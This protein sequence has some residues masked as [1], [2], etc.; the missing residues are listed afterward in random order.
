MEKR[1]GVKPSPT[2]WVLP[3][4]CWQTS[5]KPQRSLYLLYT[6]FCLST[7]WTSTDANESRCHQ[8]K[9]LYGVGL[10]TGG[11]NHLQL[12]K[13][14]L[15]FQACWAA[16]CLDSA[17]HALWWLEGMCFQA[18]C[19][20]SQSCQPFRT[21][22]SNSMVIFF[23]KSQTA[24]DLGVLPEDGEPHLLRLSWGR[25]SWKRQ[26]LPG[27]PLT[28]SVPSSDHQSLLRDRQKRDHLSEVAT[29][30]VIQHSK[31]NHS[32]EAGAANRNASA[33]DRKAVTVPRPFTAGHTTHTPDWPKNVST[34]PESSEHASPASNT[35]HVKST[36]HSPTDTPL[37]VAPSYS[38]ATPTPPASFQS[39]SASH[40]AVKD[41]VVSAGRSVQITLPT[42]EVQLNAF[43]LP[44]AE[45]GE[46][47]TYDWQL[48]THP[49]DYSGEMER[50]HSQILQLSKLTP[51]LY[52]F[53]VIVDGQNAHGEGYVNVTVKPE[54][55][56][57]RP[58]IAI[59]S[60]QFQEISLPTTSTIIDGSQSTDDDK[61]VQYHWEELKGPLR[62][63]KI[64]EDTPILKLSKLVP[65]NYTFSLTVVDS[66]GATNSTTASL[67]VNK[68]VDYPPV[69]NAG[70]N[71]VITLP[72]NSITLFGNQSTD[73]HGITSYEWSLSPSSK[74]KVV[75]MQGVR[76]PTL[77]LSAMQEGDYTYQLTVTDTTG[78]QATAQVTVIVQPENN[79]PPQADA[80][81]DKELTLPVDSTTLDGSKSTDDQRIVSYLW[82]QTQ[83]PDGVQ[84][85]DANSSVATVTG[86][87]VGTYV[88]TLTVK[89]ERDLQ[90]QSSVNVIVKEEINKPP[91]AK[92]AGNVVVTLPTSTAE[93]D[94]SR[95]SDDKGIVSYLW[96][97]DEGSPAAGEVLNHSDHHPVLFLSNLV[98]GTYTFH[99]KVTDAKGESDTDR[100][101]VEVKPDPRKSNL[102]E[103]ILD[104]N[105]S[106]LTERLKGMFIRQIGVLLGVLDSDIIVQKIQPYTEQ[107]T[108]MLFFVQNEP[109]HQLFKGH[110]V[111]AML[112]SELRKQK[113]DF[114]IFRALEINTVTCQLN[115]SDHGHCDSFTKR[116][117]CDPFW[118]ENFIKVQLRDGDSNC[119]WSV[120]YVII[121]TFVI[122][123]AL[124]ILSWTTIC[125]CKRQKGK[126]KRKSRY[127]I[128]D[129]TDQESLE[130][131]PTSR[132]GSKQKGPMLSSSL[133]HS[134]SELDSDDAIFT[135]P[136][137]EKGKLLH[138]QNGSVPNGQTPLK[139]RSP[140]E[141]IL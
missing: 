117:V 1:L 55:R 51:G 92:I 6:F 108:K 64:S 16:C 2:S 109:P 24:N 8:G 141:E 11:E 44:E 61:I 139:T 15:P 49:K 88:F 70:P 34:H 114:L 57:N 53:K 52:E 7:L 104:V 42:N 120:L 87:Q 84:L 119:E 20:K 102:V 35:Q 78:Q 36:E 5:V 45:P 12:L 27:A 56:K 96:T 73:D 100:T 33:E 93:L 86:L 122:V 124:G 90:S 131:K 43:V 76:T 14:S 125:C 121:A 107:S 89:D 111:A 47:Y 99:L 106:Q 116:C 4:Y 98:E 126:P 97:R 75:E 26:S 71:Q 62:E 133:M 136:D 112:K 9:T 40:P 83:G 19:S 137:R 63:E 138:G 113:A 81:P 105:V 74:G 140:R 66:D 10:R 128:L 50:K 60:P 85:E 29:P 23:Q 77:Q 94:G 65:G 110:E 48:I 21:D 67:T 132:A 13:G 58:P 127:K 95:S 72:Q 101:T 118:M 68:A 17:C 134:E 91:V 80:G 46:T 54:P 18:D 79:K 22:S 38:Y 30:E 130:L 28:L 3:G 31:G 41:L 39:T 37:P 115:C 103:I 25:T 59:V 69:A 135:W 129:A 32:E 82:E 123:V